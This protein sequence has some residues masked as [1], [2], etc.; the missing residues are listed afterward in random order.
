[1]E[2]PLP[3]HGD[4]L[5][6]SGTRPAV[7]ES[8]VA[9]ARASGADR[10]SDPVGPLHRAAE[11]GAIAL[12]G[13]SCT[14]AGARLAQAIA[15]P[16][17]LLL[18]LIALPLALAL[19]DAVSG[20]LHWA[21]DRVLPTSWP[22][23]GPVFVQPFHDHHRDPLGI[24]RCDFADTNGNNCLLSWPLALWAFGASGGAS[25]GTLEIFTSALLIQLTL[26][27]A[28]TNQVHRWAHAASVPGVVRRL[29]RARLVL[30]RRHHLRHHA[31]PYD[32]HY[33][34]T[35]GWLDLLLD[36]FLARGHSRRPSRGGMV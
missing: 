10:A 30:S 36:F 18:V 5:F 32:R 21:A 15:S 17:D 22:I 12:V 35:T 26:A 2:H 8:E 24:T 23:V 34:I 6:D 29:Q 20:L 25:P 4:R 7:R 27:L 11:Q 9:A 1:M 13:L 28:L 31:P 16:A 3:R 14:G 19:A 33:C